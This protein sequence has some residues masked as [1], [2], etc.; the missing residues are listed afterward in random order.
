M[1]LPFLNRNNELSRL[2]RAISS[3]NGSFCCL[4]GR[5]RCGKSRL[6]RQVLPAE[7]SAFYVADRREPSL[8]KR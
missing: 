1:R 6:L 8:L 7:G 3:K 4:Y 5:R 2:E